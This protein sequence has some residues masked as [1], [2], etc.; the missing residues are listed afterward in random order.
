MYKYMVKQLRNLQLQ[1]QP[2]KLQ[3]KPRG[4]LSDPFNTDLGIFQGITLV[5]RDSGGDVEGRGG[6]S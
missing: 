4:P 2:F 3:I 6:D 5:F 1:I